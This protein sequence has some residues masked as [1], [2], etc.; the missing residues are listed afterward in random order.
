MSAHSKDILS[1][2]HVTNRF[3]KQLVHDDVSFEIPRGEIVGFV[4]GSGAGKSVMLKTM[5]GLH[6][7]TKGTVSIN[8]QLLKDIP[9]KK[10]ASLFG[11]MFQQGALFSSL[12]V[13][14][15][16]MFPLAEHTKLKPSD[17]AQL[18]AF[19]LSL[20]GLG[21][22]VGDKYPSELSGG[23]T[24]RAS[25]ARALALDPP[26]L[27]LDEPTAGLD[28]VSATA[29]DEMIAMLNQTL[30]VTI[31]MVTHD[32]DTLFTICTK[33]AVLVDHKVIIDGLDALLD[34]DHPWIHDYLHGPRAYGAR[35]AAEK[36][37]AHG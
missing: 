15:N 8:G 21:P 5:T 19:K 22:E 25:L 31:V 4:G 11:V 32:L 7:P 28:P 23:M 27:F 26:L 18:A 14:Q 9:R 16:I 30:G 34:S 33:A 12:T 24:K 2:S 35:V 10:K 1:V 6:K 17:Q 29:F 3:G 37:T 36:A 20:V 13:A